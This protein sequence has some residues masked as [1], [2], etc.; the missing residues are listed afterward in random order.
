M[1]SF[2]LDTNTFNICNESP[3]LNFDV[4]PLEAYKLFVTDELWHIIVEE[5]N[6]KSDGSQI[7][8]Y[9]TKRRVCKMGTFLSYASLSAKHEEHHTATDY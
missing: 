7:K 8:N 9:T 4:S 5:T 3:E 2:V 6:R 1:P